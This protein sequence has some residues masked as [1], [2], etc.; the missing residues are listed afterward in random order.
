[1]RTIPPGLTFLLVIILM[2]P[3]LIGAQGSKEKDATGNPEADSKL[4]RKPFGQFVTVDGPVDDEFVSRVTNLTQELQVRAVRE[5]FQAVLVFEIRSGSS[6][7]GQIHDL[8]RVLLSPELTSVRTVAWIPKT[9]TGSHAILALACHDILMHPEAALGDIGRGTTLSDVEQNFVLDIV[10]RGRNLHMSRAIAKGMM[11]PATTI[12]RVSREDREGRPQQQFIT[13]SELRDLQNQNVV[14]AETERIKNSG[15]PGL[16]NASE[17]ARAGFLVAGTPSNRNDVVDLLGLPLES[18]REVGSQETNIEP[19]VIAINDVIGK[20]LADFIQR[21]TQHAIADGANL[22]IYDIDSPGGDKEYAQEVATLIAELDSSKVTSVAWVGR[23]TTQA[24]AL[25]ALSCDRIFM[26]T[27][28]TIGSIDVK[29]MRM[30]HGQTL[31]PANELNPEDQQRLLTIVTS[32]A[33]RKNRS[34]SLMQAMV[35]A[36]LPVFE[37]THRESGRVAWMNANEIAAQ[38]EEWTQGA[39]IPELHEGGL[40]QLTAERAHE[41][42]VSERPCHDFEELRT[43]LGIGST[44]DLR[45]VSKTWVDNLVTVLNSGV[46]GFLLITIGI[47]CIYLELHLPS[48]LFLIG[49]ITSFALFFWSRFLGGSAGTLELMLFVLGMVLLGVEVFVIPG[50]GVFGVSGILL[51]VASLV[52]ASNTFAGMSATESFEQSMSSLGSLAVA[53]MVVIAVAVLFNRFLPTIPFI[54]RLILTPPGY[55]ANDGDEPQLNPTLLSRTTSSG[56]ITA[57]M[58]GTT[59]STL[60]PTGKAMFGDL[61]VDVVSDGAYIDHGAQIEVL[62]IAGNRIIVRETEKSVG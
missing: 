39:I 60:R 7:Q 19:R 45:P 29:T 32:I 14:I 44:A 62:R 3:A 47:I 33:K 35:D 1:M 26:A 24:G 59:A 56:A 52:M 4:P 11:D 9:L 50:F 38:P 27:D 5:K 41:L 21:E 43:R 57:G 25:V 13:E 15:Q 8:A 6:R 53:L 30:N 16:F 61:Y 40:L 51:T 28:A 49:A 18:M 34:V 37:V 54:N 31:E 20:L 42:G 48:G 55:A 10:D 12:L 23:A 36:S 22:I 2:S 46:A 17:S 58:I